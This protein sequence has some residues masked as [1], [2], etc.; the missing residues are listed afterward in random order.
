[1][2]PLVPE[3]MAPLAP[4]PVAPLPL[5]PV[6]LAPPTLPD[7][8]AGSVPAVVALPLVLPAPPVPPLAL[9]DMSPVLAVPPVV[10]APLPIDEPAPEAPSAPALPPPPMPIDVHPASIIASRPAKST[11]CSL[12]FMINSFGWVFFVCVRDNAACHWGKRRD[13]EQRSPVWVGCVS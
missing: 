1:M 5:A 8:E 3:P 2:A 7:A 11:L 13:F 10:P 12:R 6:A 9:P 4:E